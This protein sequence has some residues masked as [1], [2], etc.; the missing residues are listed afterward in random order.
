VD[1]AFDVSCAV[2]HNYN[3]AFAMLSLRKR[4]RKWVFRLYL[5]G[6]ARYLWILQSRM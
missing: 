5:Q 1:E 2:H 3:A 4:F 6:I